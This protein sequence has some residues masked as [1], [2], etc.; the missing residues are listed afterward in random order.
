M[1]RDCP[2]I[3]SGTKCIRASRVAELLGLSIHTLRRWRGRGIGPPWLAIGERIVAY[4]VDELV[5]WLD[6]EQARR[7]HS[8]G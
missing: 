6:A 1:E 8:A 2:I 4:P 3:W 5:G 7:T